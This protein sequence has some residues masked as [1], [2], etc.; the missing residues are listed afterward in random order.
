MR[1][2]K[3]VSIIKNNFFL[4]VF[5]LSC[6]CSW[7]QLIALPYK[8]AFLMSLSNR[9]LLFLWLIG[10][11]YALFRR[12]LRPIPAKS[13]S[14][15]LVIIFSLVAWIFAAI[16]RS[17]AIIDNILRILGFFMLPAMIGYSGL[18]KIDS[19]AKTV[20]FIYALATALLFI[21]LY[22][23]D[24]CHIFYSDYGIR[25]LEEVTLGYSNPNQTAIYLF[26]NVLVLIPGIFYFKRRILKAVFLVA[27][28]YTGW[29]LSKTDSRTAILLL[30]LFL[31]LCLY[32]R[33]HKITK[34]WVIAACFAPLFYLLLLPILESSNTSIQIMEADLFNGRDTIFDRYWS[35]IN[36]LTF[37]F[38]DLN[39]FRM[40]NLHNGYIAV[41]ASAGFFTTAFYLRHLWSHLEWNLPKLSSPM[42]ERAAFIGFLCVLMYACSE[43]AF[44]VGG[45]HYAFIGFSVFILFA[46]PFA[47]ETTS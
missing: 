17:S 30:A 45:S 23:T 13:I 20:V 2:K 28:L 43:A 1:K 32:A 14:L 42:Y 27:S 26:S 12:L 38:G 9:A 36:A 15:L 29:I 39:R 3:N 18:F 37:L 6:I 22:H 24:Y 46:K 34:L 40:D 44:F 33:K 5:T 31:L 47:E 21:W 8:N 41:A 25:Y 16:N 7:V 19:R 4:I 11:G 10:A 35:N